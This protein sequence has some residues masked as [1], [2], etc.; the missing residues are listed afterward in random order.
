[1]H[2]V[3]GDRKSIDRLKKK[4]YAF[5]FPSWGSRAGPLALA[6]MVP[7][8]KEHPTMN[9][10][11]ELE[12]WAISFNESSAQE[13]NEKPKV[14]LLWGTK[15]PILGKLL[16]RFKEAFTHAIVVETDAGH[17]LQEEC[18]EKFSSLIAKV[19]YF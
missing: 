14:A 19:T 6:R 7:D 16:F 2:R 4:A 15:D 1:M 13:S 12:A 9:I 10:L 17:F 18:P 11:K 3:Q 8:Y 5:P